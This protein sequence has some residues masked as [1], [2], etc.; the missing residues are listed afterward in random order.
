[1]STLHDEFAQA[2]D[3]RYLNHAAVGPWPKCAVAA[4]QKSATENV[5]RGAWGYPDRMEVEQRLRERLARLLNAAP[6]DDI[7]PVKNTSQALSLS[8]LAS[9]GNTWG[10]RRHQRRSACVQPGRLG[11]AQ[12]S[13]RQRHSR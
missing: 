7:A 6:T 3:L 4:V 1:M 11:S 2:V 10:Q 9:I 8:L 5:L 13:R 12:V